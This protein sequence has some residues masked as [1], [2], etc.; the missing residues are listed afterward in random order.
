MFVDKDASSTVN[1]EGLVTIQNNKQR[2]MVESDDRPVISNVYLP[3]FSKSLNISGELT[4]TDDA[5]SKIGIT[6]PMRNKE[7]SYKKNTFSPVAVASDKVN[8]QKAWEKGNFLDDQEW[9]FTNEDKTTYYLDNQN[10][11]LSNKA[12][13][14]GWTWANVVRREPKSGDLSGEVTDN[15]NITNIN[16]PHDLAWLISLT[17]NMNGVDPGIDDLAGKTIS[18][19]NDI[20][21]KQYVWVPVGTNDKPLSGTYDGQGHLID[22]LA[23]EYLSQ[24]DHRYNRTNYGLFGDVNGGTINR[25]FVVGGL[26][27]PDSIPYQSNTKVDLPVYNIGGLA[28]YLEG[29]SVVSNSEAAIAISSCDTYTAYAG[30]LVGE[31]KSGEI[32]SS[33]A[34]PEMTIKA[35]STSEAPSMAGGLV[36]KSLG[37]SVNNSF[38]NAKFVFK[39]GGQGGGLLGTNKGTK[40]KNCYVALRETT[41]SDNF[42]GLVKTQSSGSIDSCYVQDGY[43]FAN[44]GSFD[45]NFTPVFN[46]DTYGYMYSDNKVLDADTAMFRLLNHWV[47][48]TNKTTQKYA[49]WTRPT[50]H[51]INGDLPVLMLCNYDGTGEEGQGDFRSMATYKQGPALQYGGPVRDDDQLNTALGR[52]KADASKSE[53]LF[54][55]GDSDRTETINVDVAN[56]TSD[57]IA[58]Y[59]HAAILA[60][61]TLASFE[62]TFVGVT[63][64]NTSRKATDFYG[65][66]LDRDWHMF[67]T[68]LSNA[69][70]GINYEGQ[71]TPDGP[72]YNHWTEDTYIYHDLYKFAFYAADDYDGYFPSEPEATTGTSGSY[73]YPYD[74]YCWY[75]PEWQWINFKRNGISHYHEDAPLD[76]QRILICSRMAI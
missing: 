76:M 6:S 12:L 33:M 70:L 29:S 40:V 71:N 58:I 46:T 23:I 20:N 24:T 66:Q 28:G 55:Y 7:D 19:T 22:G 31:L 49:H 13:Y 39:N 26:I 3:T 8:A 57:S 67:S 59:E 44:S 18:Q 61:G 21:L 11:S 73:G 68:P 14:F 17:S 37:G 4:A 25:T 43:T 5:T 47:D 45:K 52:P 75:E 1:V 62:K 30:G 56:I 64:D 32:H 35:K 42:D 41:A 36:G 16:S 34:M 38:V 9:F 10:T 27:V 74:F 15:F 50:L 2:R 54:I 60:P 51:S 53:R 65:E 63:F 48:K 69:P 72:S